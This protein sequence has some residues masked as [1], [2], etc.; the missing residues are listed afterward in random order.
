MRTWTRGSGAAE[1][2]GGI[3]GIKL[4]AGRLI[5]EWAEVH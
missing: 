2:L 5:R 1:G 3:V 4:G